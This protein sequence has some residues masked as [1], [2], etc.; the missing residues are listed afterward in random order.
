MGYKNKKSI[1]L[2]VQEALEAK[3][4]IGYSKHQDK[5]LGIADQ[6]IYS[7]STFQTYMK[8]C[9]YFTKWAKQEHGCKTIDAARPYVDEYLQK[10]I[11][12]GKSPYT[13]K[14]TASA[15]AK[16]YGC[17]TTDFIKTG[18][19]NRAG[20]SRSRGSAE[21]DRHFS[22]EKNQELVNFCECTGLRRSELQAL[23]KEQLV[24]EAD[25]T[26]W[27]EIKGK[28]GRER[29]APIVGTQE[30]VEA[31]V[32]RIRASEGLVWDKVH[33]AADIHGYRATYATRVYQQYARPIDQI[34]YDRV[35]KGS[36]KRYQS[37]V[38][39]CKGDLKGVAYDKA[40]MLVASRALGHNRI[41]VI[42]GHY[43]R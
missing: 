13:Q 15:L 22:A 24:E 28:G 19:R 25:G 39:H 7:W 34:P 38:Y 26:F 8:H 41:S 35:N 20:I 37:E 43:I 33:N 18:E 6:H 32:G 21:R 4:K 36:G 14:L 31:V 16:M 10:C 1:V 17:R 11:D 3:L 40:A 42:A 29:L 9:N 5:A 30:Q 27:L 23:R 2:Q 12:E